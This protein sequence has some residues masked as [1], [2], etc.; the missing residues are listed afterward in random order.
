L[1]EDAELINTVTE[2]ILASPAAL[3]AR[4][5]SKKLPAAPSSGRGGMPMQ[6]YDNPFSPFARKV[7]MV[8]EQKTI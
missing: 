5:V 8:L 3:L 6:L 1:A 2:P 7:R 4:S